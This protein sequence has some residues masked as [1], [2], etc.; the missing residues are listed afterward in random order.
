[1]GDWILHEGSASSI[2]QTSKLRRPIFPFGPYP[3][4]LFCE[5]N[6]CKIRLRGV[7]FELLK[8]QPLQQ[9]D[10]VFFF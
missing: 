7:D 2:T 6:V 5:K 3:S 8:K 4:V 1:M 10:L 9:S